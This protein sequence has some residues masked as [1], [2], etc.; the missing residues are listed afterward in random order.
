[1]AHWLRFETDGR[2]GFGTLGGSEI[3]VHRG[4][5]FGDP[6]PTG[7]TL[8][9]DEVRLLTPC[10]PGKIVAL[11]N[12][13]H[14]LSQKLGVGTPD[15]P[16]YLLKASSC[17]L[18]PGG[19]VR[20]PESYSG[21]IAYEGELGIVIGRSCR[22]ATAAG[23][24][25]AIFGYTCVNDITAADLIQKDPT[26]PQWARAKSFDGFGPFGPVIA[27]D[28]DPAALVVRTVLNGEERQNYP[29]SDMIFPAA[30]L[31][32]RLSQDMTLHPGDLVC[33]GTSLG[34]GTMKA[35]ENAVEII[36]DG[37][38]TLATRFLQ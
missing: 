13:F 2:E 1:M 24:Q 9:L 10:A 14:A 25:S 36:I 26:F 18:P 37:I 8:L 22:D 7:E 19:T 3:A 32:R 4:D 20:R 17:A 29:I 21:R 38:G 30:E 5:M 35:P 23:A 15:D 12:N 31:V 27:T 28:I 16:L 6:E 11:W 33:C 34:V